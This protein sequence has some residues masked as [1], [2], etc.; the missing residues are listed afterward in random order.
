MGSQTLWKSGHAFEAETSVLS[1]PS[2]EGSWP[3]SSPPLQF[4]P[5]GTLRNPFQMR[6]SFDLYRKPSSLSSRTN[7]MRFP[8]FLSHRDFPIP[9]RGAL[10]QSL[11]FSFPS[12]PQTQ[13]HLCVSVTSGQSWPM[14]SKLLCC[15]G[16][17]TRTGDPAAHQVLRER[18]SKPQSHADQMA[19]QC[20]CI[21][22]FSG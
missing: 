11:S 4:Q 20:L 1:L 21:F 14:V 9:A 17:H 15:L 18:L 13:Q 19:V 7:E 22:H 8:T 6:R 2:Y 5:K 16:M 3:Q 12:F 10:E